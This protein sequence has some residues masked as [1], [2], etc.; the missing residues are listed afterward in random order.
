MKYLLDTHII[1]WALVNDPRL[2]KTVKDIIMDSDN[3]IYYSTVSA[4]EVEIKHHKN[5][6]FKLTGEQLIFLCDQNGLINI[7][8]QNEHIKELKELYQNKIEHKDPFDK[9][10]ISQAMHEKMILI[11]HDEKF[12]EYKNKNIMIV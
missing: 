10:L 5:K 6:K 11:T 8:I 2:S 7:P 9:M 12:K 4:W 1:L 3:F